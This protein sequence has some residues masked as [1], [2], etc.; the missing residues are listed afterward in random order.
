M[1]GLQIQKARALSA[2]Q[3]P[4]EALA[5]ISQAAADFA[6]DADIRA[7]LAQQLEYAGESD[8]AT[9]SLARGP[10]PRAR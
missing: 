4:D 8:E 3:R 10:A 6:D 5:V 9:R 7:E 2:L 1:P